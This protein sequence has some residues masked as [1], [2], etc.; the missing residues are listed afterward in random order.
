MY[1]TTLLI[2]F[3]Y[4]CGR[5]FGVL[6]SLADVA[7]Y[8]LVTRGIGVVGYVPEVVVVVFFLAALVVVV[9]FSVGASVVTS[10]FGA[11]GSASHTMPFLLP[12]SL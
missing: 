1:A 8:G 11:P 9:D 6:R 3:S 12:S 5:L 4:Y 2:F 10:G 7:G